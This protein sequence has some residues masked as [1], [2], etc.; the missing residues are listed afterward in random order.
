MS[1]VG[2]LQTQVADIKLWRKGLIAPEGDLEQFKEWVVMQLGENL[3]PLI[4][5]EARAVSHELGDVH[6]AINELSDLMDEV[7]EH[8]ESFLRPEVGKQFTETFL[9]G[10]TICELVAGLDPNDDL[11]KKKLTDAMNKYQQQAL[12]A[13][14]EI[15]Q[16]MADDDEEDEDDDDART[17][18][19]KLHGKGGHPQGVDAGGEDAAG[20]GGRSGEADDSQ[21]EGGE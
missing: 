6:E 21:S 16:I 18:R 7:I 12:V 4:E 2:K 20:S 13:L 11:G 3:G 10:L 19:T 14:D 17:E 15:E 1:L 9:L 8:E 5:A